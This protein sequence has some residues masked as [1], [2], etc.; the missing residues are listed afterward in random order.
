MRWAILLAVLSLP[1]LACLDG[2]HD[3]RAIDAWAMYSKPGNCKGAEPCVDGYRTRQL[4]RQWMPIYIADLGLPPDTRFVN[5]L[6]LLNVTHPASDGA[7][8]KIFAMLADD[9]GMADVG[10]R[11]DRQWVFR[12]QSSPETGSQRV[13]Q[14]AWVSVQAGR[15]W[16]R[17]WYAGDG[18]FDRGRCSYGLR[19]SVPVWPIAGP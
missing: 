3:P 18:D 6:A 10:N 13:T 1:T 19:L 12:V 8:C 4:K 2:P 11:K 15:F 7:T 9:E 5:V 16:L 17:Y 14:S